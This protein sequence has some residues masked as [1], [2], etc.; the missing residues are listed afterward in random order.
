MHLLLLLMLVSAI[1]IV[2][3]VAL[4][5][6]A[7]VVVVAGLEGEVAGLVAVVGLVDPV[8]TVLVL[9]QTLVGGSSCRHH[10]IDW[11]CL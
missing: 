2:V 10:W 11:I 7:V 5:I 1:R 9:D 4:F 3:V 6:L 8:A